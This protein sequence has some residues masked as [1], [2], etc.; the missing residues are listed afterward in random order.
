MNLFKISWKNLVNR[1]LGMILS[2]VLFALGVGLISLIFLLN[3]QLEEKFDKNLAGID[4]VIGAKGSPLQLILSSMFHIDAPTGNISIG[5]AKPFL[6]PGHPLIE[7]AIPLSLGDSYRG[8]RIIGTTHDIT[9]LYE[10]SIGEGRLWEEV[11]D[12]AVGATVAAKAGLKIGDEF[13]STHGLGINEDLVHDDADAFRVVGILQPTGSV[14]DQL[15]LTSA[16]SVWAVHEGHGPADEDDHDHEEGDDHAGH[17]HAAEE[18]GHDHADDASKPLHEMVD[19]DITSILVQFKARN[20][21]TLNMPRA[22]NENTG[23][24]AANPSYEISKLLDQLGVGEKILRVLAFVIIAVS[25]LSIFI[26]LLNSL[27]ER[28]YELAIMRTLGASR[29]KLFFLIILE[30]LILAGLG[31]LIGILISHLG[32]EFFA[33]YMQDAYRYNFSGWTFLPVE[34][35]LLP[36]ALAIGFLAAVIPAIKAM[37]TE[38]SKTLAEG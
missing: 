10:A 13:R 11:M 8:F 25:S 19:K 37:R 6:R 32:M 22:I 36:G 12:V 24:M 28:R 23:M 1:P 14:I 7:K 31:Y 16:N 18:D 29:G 15:I 34:W 20:V 9:G 2:L 35:M 33:G 26:S 27:K 3:H 30:G 17:D 4:M 21:Q 38:I 5:E